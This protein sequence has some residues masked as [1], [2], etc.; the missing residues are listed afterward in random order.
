MGDAALARRL[1]ASFLADI[2]A[3]IDALAEAAA[4]AD[5]R[6]VQR[7]AHKIQGAALNMGAERLGGIAA[8]L[9]KAGSESDLDGARRFLP[10]LRAG[11]LDLKTAMEARSL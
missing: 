2:P 10:E 8:S 7:Q 5:A 6:T 4:A 11:F 1:E 9:E 3:Q